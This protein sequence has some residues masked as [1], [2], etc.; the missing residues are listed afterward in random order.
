VRVYYDPQTVSYE[1]LLYVFWRNVDPLDDGGQFC[2]RGSPYYTG[3]FYETE[4]QRRLAEESRD[5]LDQSGTFSREIVTEIM[6]LDVIDND[7]ND[8]FWVAEDYHQDYYRTNASRYRFYKESCGRV[9]R[10][11][12]LWGD[13]AGAPSYSK[14]DA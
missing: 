5:E 8:G 10:L 1:D 14:S 13:E 6:P 3:I 7:D 12:Q 9:R 11:E 2:D 4:E